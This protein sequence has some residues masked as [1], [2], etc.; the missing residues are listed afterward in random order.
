MDEFP[1]TLHAFASTFPDETACWAWLRRRR[2]P[3][4]FRCPRCT[5]RESY[6]LAERSLEQCVRC[7]YQAS[8]TAGTVLHKTRVP[9]RTW[10][11]AIFFVARHKQGIS[12]L[13]L[14]RDA[15]LGSYKTAWL[16]LHKLRAA[17]GPDPTRLLRGRVEADESYLF[18]PHEKGRGGGR[19]AGRKTLVAAVVERMEHGHLRL[20]VVRSHTFEDDLGPFVRGAIEARRVTALHTD[21]LDAYRPLARAAGVRHVR[22]V[23]GLDRSRGV[24]LLPRSHAV[25]SNLK[26]WL[27]GTFH[28]VSAKHLPRYLDE[29]VYRFNL[30]GRELAI[31]AFTASRALA[32][33]PFPYALLVGQR[34]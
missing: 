3:K 9:L 21:G 31:G 20:G 28:G 2:W 15:G 1:A 29:F 10:L 17:L 7:R 16:L 32:H 12:A 5:G 22:R 14:Q 26:S 33:P 4:G 25:F 13:Q 23:Q 11:L 18:A 27:R 34:S 8:V 24:K 30:R 6:W 19:A